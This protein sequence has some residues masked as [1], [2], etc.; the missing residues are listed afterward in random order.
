MAVRNQ[1]RTTGVLE[2]G[3]AVAV[4]LFPAIPVRLIIGQLPFT[5]IGLLVAR[6]AGAALLSLA[7]ACWWVA[8]SGAVRAMLLYTAVIIVQLLCSRVGLAL[9]VIAFGPVLIIHVMLGG[10]CVVGLQH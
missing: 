6:I 10:W 4:L 2:G 9:S 3:T 1:L 7:M 8:A 5:E